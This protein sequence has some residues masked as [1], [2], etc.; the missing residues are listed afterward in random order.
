MLNSAEE[1]AY[2]AMSLHQRIASRYADIEQAHQS[3]R[4]AAAKTLLDMAIEVRRVYP[5]ACR[6]VFARPV[7]F[8]PVQ[9]DMQILAVLGETGDADL[10]DEPVDGDDPDEG[11]DETH[12][13][14]DVEEV[15]S[16]FGVKDEDD[17]YWPREGGHEHAVVIHLP[18]F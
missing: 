15:I 11:F 5:D 10:R 13:A 14:R 8:D 16:V 7:A 17:I 12:V 2:V 6:L 18:Q 4:R 9:D 1:R 3:N